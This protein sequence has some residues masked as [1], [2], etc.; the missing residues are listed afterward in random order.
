MPGVYAYIGVTGYRP[1]ML[2][3]RCLHVGLMYQPHNTRYVAVVAR[4]V[5]R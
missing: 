4:A 5:K 3:G 1:W 2:A